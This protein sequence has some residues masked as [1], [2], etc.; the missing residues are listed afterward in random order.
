MADK[1]HVK[2]V[3]CRVEGIKAH[4]FDYGVFAKITDL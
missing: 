2:E 1:Q 3:F 4:R